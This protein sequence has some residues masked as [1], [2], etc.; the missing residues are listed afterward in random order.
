MI[1]FMPIFS[2]RPESGREGL[3]KIMPNH[4]QKLNS[5]NVMRTQFLL[6]SK[7]ATGDTV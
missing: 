6:S 5:L 4:P 2:L 1:F 7:E 3:N